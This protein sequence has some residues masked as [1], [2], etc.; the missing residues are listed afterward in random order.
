MFLDVVVVTAAVMISLEFR[1]VSVLRLI[2]QHVQIS[3][4]PV[5]QCHD[6]QRISCTSIIDVYQ[7]PVPG[8]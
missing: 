8:T 7:V 6:G 5:L 4:L 1:S 3:T 2:L